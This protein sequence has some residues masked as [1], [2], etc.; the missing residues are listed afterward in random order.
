MSLRPRQNNSQRYPLETQQE[1]THTVQ[2]SRLRLP[3]LQAEE[4][5]NPLCGPAETLD[6]LHE[7]A[8]SWGLNANWNSCDSLLKVCFPRSAYFAHPRE[9]TLRA[10]VR[11]QQQ[12]SLPRLRKIK[13]VQHVASRDVNGCK[14]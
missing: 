11:L 6:D 13:A 7:G 1:V 9:H 12:W 10:R 2:I 4:D 3:R 14:P 5:L 8:A